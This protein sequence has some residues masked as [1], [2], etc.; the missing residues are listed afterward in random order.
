MRQNNGGRRLEL[1]ERAR[2]PRTLALVAS[3]AIWLLAS[4]GLTI[5][6]SCR[7]EREPGLEHRAESCQAWC[8]VAAGSC[9]TGPTASYDTV[10]EC[11]QECTTPDGDVGWGWGYEES[12]KADACVAEW[13][14]HTDCVAALTC[15]QQQVYFSSV[16]QDPPVEERGCYAEWDAMFDCVREHPC[17]E[18]ISK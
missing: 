15:A 13:T 1:V 8:A 16:T 18:E 4:S 3:G 7:P 6:A 5:V 14:A 11:V 17:C 10:E 9:G 12:K 2:V